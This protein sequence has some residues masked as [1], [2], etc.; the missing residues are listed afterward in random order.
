VTHCWPLPLITHA[1]FVSTLPPNPLHSA[2]VSGAAFVTGRGAVLVCGLGAAF[3][4]A[5]FGGLAT[6]PLGDTNVPVIPPLFL[7]VC[8]SAALDKSDPATQIAISRFI[9]RIFSSDVVV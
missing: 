2:A 5:G 8:A 3:A 6:V 7:S 9:E 4:D 1:I